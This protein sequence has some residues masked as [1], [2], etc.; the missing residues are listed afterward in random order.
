VSEKT[1]SAWINADSERWRKDQRARHASPSQ[2]VANI[3]QIISNLADERIKKSIELAEAEQA[4][5]QQQSRQSGKK[6]PASTT[7]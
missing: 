1:L 4:G 5:D 7:P 3:E 2:R 6:L